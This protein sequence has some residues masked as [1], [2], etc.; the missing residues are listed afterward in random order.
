MLK[1]TIVPIAVTKTATNTMITL[2]RRRLSRRWRRLFRWR[3]NSLWLHFRWKLRHVTNGNSCDFHSSRGVWRGSMSCRDEG[4]DF[5]FIRTRV[6]IVRRRTTFFR[7]NFL[8]R[9]PSLRHTTLLPT[10][11]R[12]WPSMTWSWLGF[13]ERTTVTYYYY[14]SLNFKCAYFDFKTNWRIIIII[15]C[16]YCCFSGNTVKHLT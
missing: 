2:W 11:S 10:I 13:Y 6:C 4:L 5:L 3:W 12:R 8:V 16:C 9:H 7:R 1:M 14:S 15:C